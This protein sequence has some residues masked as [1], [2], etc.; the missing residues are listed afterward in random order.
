MLVGDA[1]CHDFHHRRPGKKWTNYI[2]ARQADV[3]AE[4]PGFP[5]NYVDTWGLFRAIDEN[6]AA[7]ARAPS[8]LFE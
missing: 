2:Y 7:M 5:L 3:I 6:F 4:C 1:P 8:D